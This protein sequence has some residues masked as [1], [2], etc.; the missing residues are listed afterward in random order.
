[1]MMMKKEREIKGTHQL[2]LN[3]EVEA[4]SSATGDFYFSEESE[5]ERR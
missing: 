1:M 4:S 3:E 5:E 2:W